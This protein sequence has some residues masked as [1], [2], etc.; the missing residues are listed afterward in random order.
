[1]RRDSSRLNSKGEAA[2]TSPLASLS[3]PL[4]PGSDPDVAVKYLTLSKC[5][6]SA[7]SSGLAGARDEG[8]HRARAGGHFYLAGTVRIN[9][10]KGNP[11][12]LQLYES[13]RKNVAWPA[14]LGAHSK[15]SSETL[16]ALKEEQPD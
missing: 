8:T 11:V 2:P 14:R 12:L 10:T 13:G 4:L 7:E 6:G 5:S 9:S 16:R 1:M 15:L 3:F